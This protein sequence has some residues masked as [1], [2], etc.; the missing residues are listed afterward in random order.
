MDY[1]YQGHHPPTSISS[2]IT[3]LFKIL[4][5]QCLL[6]IFRFHNTKIASCLNFN[7]IP[8]LTRVELRVIKLI[9]KRIV[10][11]VVIM[12]KQNLAKVEKCH[13]YFHPLELVIIVNLFL[14][15]ISI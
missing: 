13:H 11:M 2:S 10:S 12:G 5:F 14:A 6:K 9:L 3:F 1:S 7:Q 8:S 4:L 15:P